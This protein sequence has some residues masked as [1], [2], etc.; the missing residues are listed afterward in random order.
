M[1]NSKRTSRLDEVVA[2][3]AHASQEFDV[4]VLQAFI[5]KYPEYARD[6]QRYAYIQLTSVPATPQEVDNEPLSAEEMLPRQSKLLKRM[7]Q[8]RGAPSALDASEAAGKLVS[9][10]GE[11]AIRAAAITVFGSCEH[12]EDLLLLSVTESVSEVR[13]VPDWFYEELG[14]HVGAAP[15]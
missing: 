11:Q 13:A 14:T 10:S 6:L 15:V 7:Q 4:K 1:S 3:Y 2:D 5:D 9:I 8:L 12:G